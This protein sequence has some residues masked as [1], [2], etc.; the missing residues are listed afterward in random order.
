MNKI[1]VINILY[2]QYNL[3]IFNNIKKLTSKI[4][5]NNL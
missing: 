5:K 4:K 2:L 1:I 3:L